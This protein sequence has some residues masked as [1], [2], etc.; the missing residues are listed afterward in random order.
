M[1]KLSLYTAILLILAGCELNQKDVKPSDEFVKIYNHSDE[2]L[3]FYPVDLVEIEGGGYLFLSGIKADSA[4]I[5]FPT[6]H[7]T[8][9]NAQGEV[10]WTR[11]YAWFAPAGIYNYSG[12]AGFIAMDLQLNTYAININLADG[13]EQSQQDLGIDMPLKS[14]VDRQNNL[15][16]LGYDYI[17][18]SSWISLFSPGFNLQSS[19][20]LLVEEDL[21]NLV[22]KHL[23]KTGQ[24]FPF[25]IGEWSDEG[26]SGYFVNCFYNYSLRAAYLDAGLSVMGNIYSYQMD[27]AL[28]SLEQRSGNVYAMSRF[29]EGNNFFLGE[30]EVDINTSQNFNDI[31]NNVL[32]ELTQKAKVLS[33]RISIGGSE[34]ILFVSQTNSNSIITY[35]QA[36]EAD[37]L[38]ATLINP[39]N[40]RVEVAGMIQTQDEG[41]A[42]LAQ[43]YVLGKYKRPMLIKNPARLYQPE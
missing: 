20:K 17:S 26:Q 21:E 2:G 43:I 29:Y 30:V 32:N 4:E 1:K 38:L 41:M 12:S 7:L 11:E 22:Q 24:Q 42:I 14:V 31:T 19:T 35:Q 33:E 36:A 40:E 34:Y 28:S 9:T 25:F 3:S 23:N 13:L 6:T 15:L 37:S 10:E 16:V 18:R 5:E 39:F 27:N 8:K